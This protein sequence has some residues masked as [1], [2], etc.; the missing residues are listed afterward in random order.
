MLKHCVDYDFLFTGGC[1]FGLFVFE[2]EAVSHFFALLGCLSLQTPQL[3][4]D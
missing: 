3:R 1:I 2:A 4:T